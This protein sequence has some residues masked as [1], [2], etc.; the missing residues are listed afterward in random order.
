[1][2]FVFLL[3]VFVFSL[4]IVLFC[5]LTFLLFGVFHVF[6]EA[7]PL[8]MLW[9]AEGDSSGRQV[10]PT[11]RL[12]KRPGQSVSIP[13]ASPSPQVYN[14]IASNG[15]GEPASIHAT[16]NVAADAAEP[17]SIQRHRRNE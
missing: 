9:G 6:A 13:V 3:S 11:C 16:T 8:G 14:V 12:S 2:A 4:L 1:M 10:G 5:S 15:T 7:S 17:A